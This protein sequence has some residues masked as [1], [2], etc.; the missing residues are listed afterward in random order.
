MMLAA[1]FAVLATVDPDLAGAGELLR[2]TDAGYESLPVESVEVDLE[3][4]GL[5][6]RG[7][8]T[9]R[10]LNPEP[11]VIEAL[12]VFPVPERAAVD[13]MEMRIGERRIVAEVRE[14]EEARRTYEAAKAEGKKASLVEQHRPNLFRTSVAN[15][16]PGEKVEVV[17]S[18]VEE[19]AWSDGAFSTAAPLTYT[20]RYTPPGAEPPPEDAFAPPATIRAR[21]AGG[22]RLDLVESPSHPIRVDTDGDA[23]VATVEG[24]PV[25]ATRD[26]VLRWAPVRAASPSATVYVEDRDDGRYALVLLV[27]PDDD[28][29]SSRGFPTATVFVLDVSGSME[30]ASLAQAKRALV[31][32]LG[33]LRPGDLFEIVKFS[34][35][36]SAWRGGF[37]PATDVDAAIAWVDGLVSEGGTE[38]V[39]AIRAGLGLLA[40]APDGLERRLVL[41][42]DGAVGNE[43]EA[44]D[45]V[46][47]DLGSARLHVVGIG[48][49]P[50][51][52][53]MRKLAETGRGACTFV[54]DIDDV[55]K[56][57]DA[58]L[59]RIDRPVIA[60]LALEW[61]GPVPLESFPATL[62]DLYAGEPLVASMRFP[63]GADEIGVRLSGRR[64][65][66]LVETGVAVASAPAESGVASRFARRKVEALVDSLQVGADEATVRAEVV[67]LG[68]RHHLV[69]PYTSLVAVEQVPT[70]DPSAMLP[71]T[72]TG[73]RRLAHLG[74]ALLGLAFAAL[75]FAG[76]S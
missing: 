44:F 61:K 18:W 49:A 51:R 39:P 45:A 26:F 56:E 6:V 32:A 60:D 30:G 25:P 70:A 38:M 11:V 66:G 8:M 19:A 17:I 16:N 37:S 76:R 68:I 28:A 71:R 41:A 36:W 40:R 57:M 63:A 3:I 73:E 43:T 64:E 33:R 46:R 22:L 7:T 34:S 47:A 54:S 21:F 23:T 53:L 15:V 58:F 12:Y 1:A 67:D 59:S 24:S 50:N 9:Q 10:F 52:W 69:T 72:G 74:I 13:A 42:T 4:A 20:P 27:P 35:E 65:R 29:P 14:R 5:L 75:W 48:A 2:R 55:G 31:A 62:P